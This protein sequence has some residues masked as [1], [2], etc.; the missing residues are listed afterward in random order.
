MTKTKMTTSEKLLP[1]PEGCPFCGSQPRIERGKRGSCQLHGE[2]F[3]GVVIR[4]AKHECPVKPKVQAG[5]IFNG[6]EE[7]AKQEAIQIWNTR[8]PAQD[9]LREKVEQL[10]QHYESSN[11]DGATGLTGHGVAFVLRSLIPQPPKSEE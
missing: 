10:A 9:G 4:C 3:Q 2:P 6:G 5:D 8:I 7:K 11:P 1:K